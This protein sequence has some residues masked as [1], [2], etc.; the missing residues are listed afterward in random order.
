MPLAILGILVASAVAMFE[1][2]LKRLLATS[3]VAQ[4]G[5]ILLGAGFVSQAG[6]NASVMH[7]FNHALAKGGLF[8]AV[9]CLAYHYRDLRLSQ[10]GGA[11]ARMPLTSAALVVCGLSLIGIPGTAGFISKWL[12]IVA[13]LESGPWGWVLV[14]VILISS[15][16]AVVYIWRIVEAL[17]FKAPVE[18]DSPSSEAPLQLL[19]VTWLVALLNIYFGLFPGIPLELA[20]GTAALLVG[21]G[22]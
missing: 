20:N 1:G 12:L 18:H 3:S 7:L 14:V 5:Y 11:A 8:L 10:L 13:A 15:L 6:L 22:S 16:M 19:L 9:A 17:Y 4:I 21:G 2:H